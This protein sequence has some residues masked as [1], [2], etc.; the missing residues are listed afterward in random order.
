MSDAYY[1]AL[2]AQL[3][4]LQSS[5]PEGLETEE[6]AAV[7]RALHTLQSW[8]TQQIREIFEDEARDAGL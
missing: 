3:Y 4:S 7:M 8:I 2:S 1:R 6:S 5:L